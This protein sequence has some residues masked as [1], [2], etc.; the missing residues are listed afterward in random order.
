MDILNWDRL[1]EDYNNNYSYQMI[2]KVVDNNI[3]VEEDGR[4]DNTLM[5]DETVESDN[6]E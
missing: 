6:M 4:M 3:E 2:E 1:F 5:D